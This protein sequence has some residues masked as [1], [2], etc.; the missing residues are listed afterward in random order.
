MGGE[1]ELSYSQGRS[2]RLRADTEAERERWVGALQPLAVGE[3]PRPSFALLP[4]WKVAHDPA[5][6]KPY[7][8]NTAT[9][10][11]T[12]K[13]PA[14][15]GVASTK[16]EIEPAAVG[17]GQTSDP[18]T[19]ARLQRIGA[20]EQEIASLKAQRLKRR[21]QGSSHTAPHVDTAGMCAAADQPSKLRQQKELELQRLR[22]ETAR[23]RRLTQQATADD[24][25]VSPSVRLQALVLASKGALNE[26]TAKKLS[27]RRQNNAGQSSNGLT[28]GQSHGQDASVA[29]QGMV[30]AQVQELLAAAFPAE[31]DKAKVIDALA[32]QSPV[33]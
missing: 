3:P 5:K 32:S 23:R 30:V 33:P 17:S 8:Y 13:R 20:L 16:Q 27:P 6:G 1:F 14:R 10:E 9:G 4:G 7:F 24:G 2:L 19:P 15:G 28:H 11:K 22:H 25:A 18:G 21:T 31:A 26:E 29:A 12:W